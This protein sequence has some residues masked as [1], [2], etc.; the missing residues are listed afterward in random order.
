MNRM[1]MA[2]VCAMAAGGCGGGDSVPSCQEAMEHFYGAGCLF[3][4][5]SGSEI[6]VNNATGICRQAL[7]TPGCESMTGDWT[8]CLMSVPEHSTTSAECDCSQE[9]ERLLTCGR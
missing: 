4:D 5:S 3:R 8:S 7:A 1:A 6:P 9:Q 2:I